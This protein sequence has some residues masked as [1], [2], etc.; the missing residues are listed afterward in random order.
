[1]VLRTRTVSRGIG[2]AVLAATVSL[3]AVAGIPSVAAAADEAAVAPA[4]AP[5]AAVYKVHVSGMT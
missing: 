1:M 3:G 5:A 4:E 2:V